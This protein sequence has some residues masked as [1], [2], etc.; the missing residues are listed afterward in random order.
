MFWSPTSNSYS[1]LNVPVQDQSQQLSIYKMIS[2]LNISELHKMK[3]WQWKSCNNS[4]GF[5][6]KQMDSFYH[7]YTIATTCKST[8]LHYSFL[9]QEHSQYF[10]QMFLTDQEIFRCQYALLTCTKCLDI[11]NSTLSSIHHNYPHMP[12]RNNT[13]HWS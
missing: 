4:S 12:G 5:V 10:C 6:K 13:V 7:S 9:C 3:P 11:N 1:S 2:A 8:I